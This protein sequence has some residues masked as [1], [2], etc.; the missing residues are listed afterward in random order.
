VLLLLVML[1]V[2]EVG[3]DVVVMV[4]STTI[5]KTNRDT[6]LDHPLKKK[7]SKYFIDVNFGNC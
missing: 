6:D 4:R 1:V 7:E 5:M 3:W 2:A